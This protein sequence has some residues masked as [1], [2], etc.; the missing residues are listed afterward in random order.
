[1]LF[2]S[3][4]V[5]AAES[6]GLMARGVSV[7][8]TAGICSPR[9]RGWTRLRILGL[10]AHRLLPAHAGMDPRGEVLPPSYVLLPHSGYDTLPETNEG[11]RHSRSWRLR[12]IRH[13]RRE[14]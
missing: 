9:T 3:W 2:W 10:L 11:Q 7:L 12:A 6:G 14:R 5:V 13:G 4:V 8:L 1:M